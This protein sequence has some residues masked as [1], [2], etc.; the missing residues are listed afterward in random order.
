MEFFH[1][2]DGDLCG[3]DKCLKCFDSRE[4]VYRVESITAIKFNETFFLRKS[5]R[6]ESVTVLK[7]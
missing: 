1:L 7:V 2:E 3:G 4:L 6:L 5:N